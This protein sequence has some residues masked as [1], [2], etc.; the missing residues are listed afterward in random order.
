MSKRVSIWQFALALS[1]LLT[2]SKVVYAD[3]EK[4]PL[5]KVPKAVLDA[6]KAKFPEAKI[7]GAEKETDKEK[8]TVYEINISIKDQK[9]DITVTPEGKIVSVEK[10]IAV[11]DMPK[12]VAEALEKKYPK[13]TIK[14]VEE[15]SDGA[16]KI[17]KYEAVIITADNKTLEV[18]FDPSGKFL[19]EEKKEDNKGDN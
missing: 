10:V 7:N 18:S 9:A 14:Q 17:T 5:D 16:D 6:V 8:K 1:L 15:I 11:K 12:P 19:E 13:A 2:A 4:V 3:E